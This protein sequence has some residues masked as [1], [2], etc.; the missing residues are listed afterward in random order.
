MSS[1]RARVLL[2]LITASSW[3]L[4]E[5]ARGDGPPPPA[6]PVAEYAQRRARVLEELGRPSGKPGLLLL[7]APAPAHFAGDVEYPYRPDNDLF[8]L[9]GMDQEGACLLLSA[10]EIEGVGREALFLPAPSPLQG[11]WITRR[12]TPQQASALCGIP[13]KS[14]LASEKLP[15][16]L[17]KAVPPGSFHRQG[18]GGPEPPR[19]YFDGRGRSRPGEPLPDGYQFLL[20]QLGSSAFHLDLKPARQIIAP[21][22][23]VKSPREIAL[24]DRAI[25]I[26][27][28]AHRSAM[29]AARPGMF[30]YQ[31]AALIEFEFRARGAAGWAFPSIIGSGPNSCILHYDRYDRQLASG[32]LVVMD[33]GAEYGFYA[34]DVTRTIPVSG[35]FTERQR[36][37]YQIVY[38]AQEAA[39]RIIRPGIPFSDVHK[40][41]SEVVA[42]GLIGLGLIQD[43]S[44]VGK[45]FPHGTSHGLGLD[46]H[47]PMPL[48]TLSEGMVI[49]VE[50]G[51][52]LP[53]ESLGIRIEDD[54]LVTET[55]CRVLSVGAPR[56][57][58]ELERWMRSESL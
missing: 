15:A 53:E 8:Y 2:L 40:T 31:L 33:I 4:G 22:R 16:V 50:P 49:T 21:L 47:D 14:I 6:T 27:A 17:G 26:T 36:R 24:L 55:G 38:E 58:D 37:V 19:I 48:A 56:S 43:R 54:V 30:E 23:Q 51:I 5:P 28:D 1:V 3:L 41:S 11:L 7:K 44:Q 42:A 9:T 18:P 32:D 12:Y 46:V 13:E 10:A 34:A 57:A 25:Q 52:Y 45:Y 39:F 35:R 29:R 20:S